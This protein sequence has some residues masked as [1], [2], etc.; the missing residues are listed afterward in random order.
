MRPTGLPEDPAT[1][2]PVLDTLP[3]PA[4][5]TAADGTAEYMNRAARAYAGLP[6]DDLLGW[7]WGWVVHPTDLPG[8][9]EAWTHAVR[10]GEPHRV[11]HRLRRHDGQYLWFLTQG[12]PARTR[13]GRVLR[14]FGTCTEVDLLKREGDQFREARKL[15]RSL[16][17]R[18]GDGAALVAADGAVLYVNPA[19]TRVLR[20]RP[21]D[22][23]GADVRGWVHPDDLPVLRG[24]FERLMATPGERLGAHARFRHADGSYRRLEVLATNLIPDPDARAVA[25]TFRE[26]DDGQ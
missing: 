23:V 14:W 7:D 26:A 1:Y 10:T 3:V 19:V 2:G 25:V 6:L 22:L 20:H 18:S 16:V 17:E 5:A 11:E 24:W 8:T 9:L 4:W 12:A 13:D 21:E 15:F